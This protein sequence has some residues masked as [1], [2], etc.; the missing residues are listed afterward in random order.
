MPRCDAPFLVVGGG[1]KHGEAGS[2]VQD[3]AVTTAVAAMAIL[4]D[5]DEATWHLTRISS[6]KFKRR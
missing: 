1:W 6:G 5:G 2:T 3:V 4:F